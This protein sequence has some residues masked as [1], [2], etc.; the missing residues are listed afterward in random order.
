MQAVRLREPG[1]FEWVQVEEPRDLRA[2]EVLVRVRKIG[3]CGTD[4]HA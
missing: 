1:R 2:G 3:I 4:L